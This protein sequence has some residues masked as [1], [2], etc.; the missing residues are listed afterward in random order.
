MALA[1]VLAGSSEQESL[2]T[3]LAIEGVD[4]TSEDIADAIAPDMPWCS[5]HNCGHACSACWATKQGLFVWNAF[6][7]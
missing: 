1:T 4:A 3:Q 5:S 2:V 6:R 7:I